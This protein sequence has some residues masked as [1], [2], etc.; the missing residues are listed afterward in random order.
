MKNKKS[1]SNKLT[2]SPIISNEEAKQTFV[3]SLKAQNEN[4]STDSL[5]KFLMV[6]DHITNNM[7]SFS[8]DD[9][10]YSSRPFEIPP[11]IV[12]ELF[13]RYVSVL[14]QCNK[15]DAVQGCYDN[16]IYVSQ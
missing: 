10:I 6:A 14:V 16:V 7:R 15:L 9:F 12:K 1:N 5:A 2:F 3:K 11:T 8:I 13:E 4:I